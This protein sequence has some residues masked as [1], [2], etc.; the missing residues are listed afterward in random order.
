MIF[1]II[2][3]L[4]AILVTWFSAGFVIDYVWK[5]AKFSKRNSF[6]VA[7]FLLAFLTSMTEF[8]VAINSLLNGTPQIA[9]GNLVGGPFV[10]LLFL[11]PLLAILGNG[12][13]FENTFKGWQLSLIIGVIMLPSLFFLQGNINFVFGI[14]ALGAYGLL[15]WILKENS[16][17]LEEVTQKENE[18]NI[19]TT[20]YEFFMD[21]GK[22]L[23]AGALIF[24]AGD[25]IVE[26]AIYFAEALE[27][28]PSLVGIL[29][30]SFGTNVPEIAIAV[31]SLLKKQAIVALG[32][33]LGSAS[34]NT[35]TFGIIAVVGSP[36]VVDNT[37]FLL[38]FIFAALGMFLLFRFLRSEDFLSRNEGYVLLC[39]YFVF[40]G[41]QIHTLLQTIL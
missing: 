22:I 2:I 36:F 30:L 17:T 19:F 6:F 5:V 39:I 34:M 10:L 27:V 20:R 37:R 21:I 8:S 23:A 38:S 26:K 16:G 15:V 1:H 11:V 12:I 32:N 29:L 9:M 41:I 13:K 31:R 28:A 25:I 7:F 33:Y 35:L 18:V 14:I 24:W 3:F 4:V 40:I